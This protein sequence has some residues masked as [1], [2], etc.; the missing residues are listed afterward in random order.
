MPL[1]DLTGNKYVN[2]LNSDWPAG[3]DL[4]NAGDDHLR[5]IKN[6]LKRTFPNLTG[7]VTLT[8]AQLNNGVMPVGTRTIFYQAAPPLGWQRVPGIAATRGLRVV[9]S[10]A[11]GGVAGGTDDPVLNNRV[12]LHNHG[13]FNGTTGN[14][15]AK[16]TH[17]VSGTSNNQ[18]LNH[19][20]TGVTQATGTPGAPIVINVSMGGG[21]DLQVLSSGL[22]DH[23]HA[24]STTGVDSDHTHAFST[25]TAAETATHS[26]SVSVPAANNPA[27]AN[28]VP[29]YFDVILCERV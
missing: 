14:N 21:L 3:T 19:G 28:W 27:A 7:P 4:P 25:T 10:T 24:F 6:V 13:A 17:A 22:V 9:A 5:G 1:E 18:N 23:V 16:H 12:P 11:V 15:S 20:H 26:H 8:Q 29:R 2:S